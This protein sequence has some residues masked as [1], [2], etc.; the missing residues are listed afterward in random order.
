MGEPAGSP[1]QLPLRAWRSGDWRFLL[2]AGEW[3]VGY[4]GPPPLSDETDVLALAG[5]RVVPNPSA[6]NP[7]D[8]VV[9]TSVDRRSLAAGLAAVRPGGWLLL[10]LTRGAGLP[11]TGTP[12]ARRLLRRR[13]LRLGLT[14]V[15]AFWHAP[16]I[17]RCAYVVSVDDPV[18]VEVM[19]RRHQG[20]RLGLLKS[21]IGRA[22]NRLGSMELAVKDM[23]VVARS[24]VVG[25]EPPPVVPAIPVDPALIG[26][27]SSPT[28]SCSTLL[29]TPWFEASRHVLA[30]YVGPGQARILAVAKLPRRPWDVGGI[31]TEARALRMVHGG[32]GAGSPISPRVLDHVPAGRRPYLLQSGVDGTPVDPAFVR[33]STELVL[34]C[35]TALVHRLADG[36]RRGVTEKSFH[37]LVRSPLER[38]A[39]VV[40]VPEVT[41]LVTETLALLR[42]LEDAELPLVLEHGDLGHPNLL[43]QAGRMVAI[44]WERFE[45]E[46][47]PC[48]DLV[49]FLQYVKECQSSA[50]SIPAEVAAFDDAFRGPACWAAGHLRAYAAVLHLDEALVPSLVL[51]SWARIVAGLAPR[52]EPSQ[53]AA[54]V[55][56]VA[57]TVLT[58]RDYALWR[59][60]VEV[61]PRLLR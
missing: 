5:M 29:V 43:L 20:V 47:F 8:V 35:G 11:H 21:L 28:G 2:P 38:L 6:E 58:D 1:E 18:A 15:R 3:Q 37:R 42:P 54:A 24:P 56:H 49:F 19:L 4:V 26:G 60:A 30:L 40:P 55:S 25:E 51:A 46:G 36:D 13:L 32:A 39:E 9:V 48:L 23:T 50:T 52:L 57:E 33:R 22:L 41:E 44:D 12:V 31:D 10:R 14:Q 61:F 27:G 53:G 45:P 7:A 34:R 59:R 16:D 17:R